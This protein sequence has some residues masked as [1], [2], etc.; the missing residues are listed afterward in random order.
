MD[1]CGRVICVAAVL[2]CVL[3]CV[4]FVEVLFLQPIIRN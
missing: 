4:L 3:R 2:E 1:L